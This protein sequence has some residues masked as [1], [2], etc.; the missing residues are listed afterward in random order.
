MV[1]SEI[2]QKWEIEFKKGFAKPF[3][4]LTLAK[5]P[6]YAYSLTK[7][8]NVNTNGQISITVTSIYPILK[9]LQDEELIEGKKEPKP[10]KQPSLDRKPQLRTVYSL[11]PKGEQLL[12]SLS[13]SLEEFSNII[14]R[15]IDAL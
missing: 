9:N 12:N 15:H 1:Q 2:L 14:Q 10:T 7:E 11:T 6:N 4:L 5:K 8:I 13:K 3:I